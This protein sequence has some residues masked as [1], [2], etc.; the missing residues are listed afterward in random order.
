MKH[1]TYFRIG[2]LALCACVLALVIHI[3]PV[4]TVYEDPHLQCLQTQGKYQRIQLEYPV[5]FGTKPAPDAAVVADDFWMPREYIIACTQYLMASLSDVDADV[6]LSEAELQEVYA[7]NLSKAYANYCEAEGQGIA[8]NETEVKSTVS[9]WRAEN[10]KA[11]SKYYSEEE[12]AALLNGMQM[13]VE[14]YIEPNEE[15][16]RKHLMVIAMEDR[17]YEE[18]LAE[19]PE[20]LSDRY[21][22]HTAHDSAEWKEDIQNRM[23]ASFL[24]QH[25]QCHL[26]DR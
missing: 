3:T 17:W 4:Y 13:T 19:Q 11:V 15:T 24:A 21:T 9:K 25:V 26:G 1:I 20:A 7:L 6:S 2:F 8:V 5:E 16:V 14:E 22:E 12:L 23:T 10:R 18:F